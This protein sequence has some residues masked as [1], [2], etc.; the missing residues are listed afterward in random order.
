[1]APHEPNFFPLWQDTLDVACPTV[2]VRDSDGVC[3]G[4]DRCVAAEQ[5]R[6]LLVYV[7]ALFGRV[8]FITRRE[9]SKELSCSRRSVV[10][11]RDLA[12]RRPRCG[13][14][15]RGRTELGARPGRELVGRIGPTGPHLRLEDLR[16]LSTL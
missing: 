15:T 4:N 5:W 3:H 14:G 10:S 6:Q 12:L 9:T 16:L 2:A 8:W 13:I 1:M 7:S 11:L